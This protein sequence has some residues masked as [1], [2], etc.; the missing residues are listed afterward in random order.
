MTKLS[1]FFLLFFHSI[2]SGTLPIQFL[3]IS[4][5][6]LPNYVE[7]FQHIPDLAED[8]ID[9]QNALSINSWQDESNPLVSHPFSLNTLGLIRMQSEAFSKF[10]TFWKI[11][12]TFGFMIEDLVFQSP[13][14]SCFL[15]LIGDCVTKN[16]KE[17]SRF[18]IIFLDSAIF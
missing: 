1:F 11:D 12:D 7:H 13:K 14:K 2:Y 4:S 16:L 9:W 8:L 15:D 5:S 18:E 6:T 17:G 3:E 10:I